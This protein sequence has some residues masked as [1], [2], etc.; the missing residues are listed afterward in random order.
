MYKLVPRIKKKKKLSNK[1]IS[2]SFFS[3]RKK[4]KAKVLGK[5]PA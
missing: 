4:A 1:A 3:P 2:L 5:M